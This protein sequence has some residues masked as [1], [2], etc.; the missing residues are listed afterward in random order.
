[1]KDEVNAVKRL[2]HPSSFRLHPCSRRPPSRSGYCLPGFE[3]FDGERVEATTDGVDVDEGERARVRAV[4][5][6]DEDALA[7]RVNPATRSREAEVAETVG[8][9]QRACGRVGR[10]GELP[11]EGARLI[12]PFGH[13]RSEERAGRGREKRSAS[14]EELFGESKRLARGRE[15]SGVACCA[16]E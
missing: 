2:L 1:M 7:R 11:G 3:G 13:V 10:G 15:E 16:A 6:K 4:C 5:E 9:E 12:Q 8:R 14:R